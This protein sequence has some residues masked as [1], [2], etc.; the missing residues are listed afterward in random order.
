M[1]AGKA[2]RKKHEE[3]FIKEEGCRIVQRADYIGV[4]SDKK[5]S[6]TGSLHDGRSPEPR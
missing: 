6:V 4:N 2:M 3:R 5:A 1:L